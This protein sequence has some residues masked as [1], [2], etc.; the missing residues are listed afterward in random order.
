M[1]FQ[2]GPE[3]INIKSIEFIDGTRITFERAAKFIEKESKL[4]TGPYID[5]KGMRCATAV[6]ENHQPCNQCIEPVRCYSPIRKKR[7]YNRWFSGCLANECD[8]VILEETVEERCL[9][10][11]SWLRSWKRK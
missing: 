3:S 6:L 8:R 1:E 11:A 5:G 4:T 2:T 9:R 10:V 7:L